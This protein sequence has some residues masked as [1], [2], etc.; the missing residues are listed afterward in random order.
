MNST[1]KYTPPEAEAAPSDGSDVLA[2]FFEAVMQ[3]AGSSLQ[4]L[5][6]RRCVR[7]GSPAL[8]LA[9][10]AGFKPQM[11]YTVKDAAAFTGIDR[12]TLY[13]E[14]SAGRI[15]FIVPAGNDRGARI[16]V[17]EIDRWMEENVA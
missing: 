11:T 14:H 6:G 12:Q 9:V 7:A 13:K 17:A 4:K 1:V 2:G 16:S 10:E 3:A 15:A 8:A 5:T